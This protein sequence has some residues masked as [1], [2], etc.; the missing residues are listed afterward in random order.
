MKEREE[1]KVLNLRTGGGGGVCRSHAKTGQV[2]R[3]AWPRRKGGELEVILGYLGYT[4][5]SR[6]TWTT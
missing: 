3:L 1:L 4:V 2:Q 5:S 6:A